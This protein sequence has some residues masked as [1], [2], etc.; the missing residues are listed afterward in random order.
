[1]DDFK[2]VTYAYG[3]NFDKQDEAYQLDMLEEWQD[4]IVKKRYKLNCLYLIVV[5]HILLIRDSLSMIQ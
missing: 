5:Q 2:V 1:M 4:S 3:D